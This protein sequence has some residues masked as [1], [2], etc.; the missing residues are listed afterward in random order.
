MDQAVEL[1]WI[2]LGLV[3]LKAWGAVGPWG[4]GRACPAV[5]GECWDLPLR[6]LHV[7]QGDDVRCWYLRG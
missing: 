2:C 6:C 7:S 1:C 5:A 3:L 4:A